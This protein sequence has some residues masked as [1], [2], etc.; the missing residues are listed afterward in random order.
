MLKLALTLLQGLGGPSA[1]FIVLACLT[2]FVLLQC[3]RSSL[4]SLRED[5]RVL[6]SE[7]A[8]L[9]AGLTACREAAGLHDAVL[10]AREREAIEITNKYNKLREEFLRALLPAEG[11]H[12]Q[13]SRTVPEASPGEASPAPSFQDWCAQPVPDIVRGLLANPPATPG[14]S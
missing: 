3:S 11:L 13:I 10:T 9:E 1:L 12:E 4:E 7:Y 2:P 6:E 8:A 14:L 5:Y